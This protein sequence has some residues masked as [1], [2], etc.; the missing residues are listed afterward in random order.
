VPVVPLNDLRRGFDVDAAG[1]HEAVAAVLDGGWYVHGP[2]HAAFEAELARYVGVSHAIGVASGTD[3]LELALTVASSDVRRIVVTAA[4]AGGYTS[5]AAK[6][7]GL[8]LRYADVQPDTLCLDHLEVERALADDADQVAAVVLTHLYGRLGDVERIASVCADADVPLVED[9]AQAIGASRGGRRAGSFGDLATFSFYP[10]KN[11]GALGDGGAVLTDDDDLAAGL[12]SLRHTAGRASTSSTR[13]AGRTAASTRSRQPCSGA[14]CPMS[15][16]AT[17]ADARSCSATPLPEREPFACCQQRTKGTSAT[18][19][20]RCATTARAREWCLRRPG[21]TQ[22]STTR[23]DHQQPA[24]RDGH[25]GGPL[26][27]TEDAAGR[28]LTLP[29]FPELTDAEVTHVCSTLARL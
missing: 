19:R 26:P 28:L 5:V 16:S 23:P 8:A 1:L 2:E 9:C 12:R 14:V 3:A 18:W 25:Q 6:R 17:P 4:N 21:C 7:S 22:T 11:L 10:T 27:V 24:L 29:C 20:W 15:T 13:P